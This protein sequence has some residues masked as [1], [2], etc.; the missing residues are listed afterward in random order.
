MMMCTNS[1]RYQ[2]APN[3]L[4]LPD[5]IA[6]RATAGA[7][8]LPIPYEGTTSY[9][10]GTR[11]GPA[12][13][14]AASRQVEW[15]DHRVG[16]EPVVDFGVHTLN[17][18]ALSHDSPEATVTMIEDA[19]AA[20]LTGTPAPRT[21]AV[22]GG[23]HTVSVGVARGLARGG[24]SDFVV[25]QIDAHADLRAAYEGTPYSHACAARR[26]V[27]LAPIFQVGIR[28]ISA[29]G[30]RFRRGCDR[31]TTVFAE[32]ALTDRTYLDELGAFVRDKHVY[33]TIDLDGLDPSIMPA[34]G[35]PEPGG[36]LWMDVLAIVDTVAR[37]AAHVPA[38]DVVELAPIPGLRAPDF[39][40]AKLVYSIVSRVLGKGEDS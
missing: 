5:S 29:E 22:L 7:W 20:I 30:H 33:L 9:G 39:L 34:V 11:D 27:E 18:L 19:V 40:A 21:L 28:N 6:S 31:L 8:I 37:E 23:E 13:I 38:L 26:I 16:C 36:L 14:L 25:V 15:F 24:I 32:R 4:G 17:P 3:F 10:A 35:T 12:A 1:D 2:A